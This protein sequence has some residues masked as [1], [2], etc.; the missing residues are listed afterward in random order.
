MR[1]LIIDASPTLKRFLDARSKGASEA[2]LRELKAADEAA[3]DPRPRA[4]V[5]I[6]LKPH[7]SFHKD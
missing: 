2:E 5:V 1:N 7:S 6:E 4:D 3:R